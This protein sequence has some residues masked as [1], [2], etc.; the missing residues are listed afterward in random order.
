ML[1]TQDVPQ[2]FLLNVSGDLR[3]GHVLSKPQVKRGAFQAGGPVITSL[4]SRG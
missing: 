1:L 2:H 4:V 3:R